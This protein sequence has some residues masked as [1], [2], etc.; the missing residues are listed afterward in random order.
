M[1]DFLFS[2]CP[3]EIS[4]FLN[5][6]QKEVSGLRNT[7]HE[8][9]VDFKCNLRKGKMVSEKLSTQRKEIVLQEK[10]NMFQKRKSVRVTTF[11]ILGMELHFSPTYKFMLKGYFLIEN[12]SF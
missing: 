11:K 5:T 8:K 6:I 10:N 4:E 3:L 2:I 7:N 12:F 1:I 9:T